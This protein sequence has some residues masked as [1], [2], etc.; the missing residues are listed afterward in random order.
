MRTAILLII[1]GSVGLYF[2]PGWAFIGLAIATLIDIL[3]DSIGGEKAA[4][5]LLNRNTSGKGFFAKRRGK[6]RLIA[7]GSSAGLAEAEFRRRGALKTDGKV[8]WIN[9]AASL[10]EKQSFGFEYLPM[11]F[12]ANLNIQPS[13]SDINNN[14]QPDDDF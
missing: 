2:N 10:D 14:Y 11:D 3:M 7:L 9:T 1:G 4:S 13:D 12:R 5:Q 8:N 6:K